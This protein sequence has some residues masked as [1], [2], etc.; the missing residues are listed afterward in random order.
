MWPLAQ[1][2]FVDVGLIEVRVE[3]LV[4][5]FLQELHLD[6]FVGDAC[7]DHCTTLVKVG[8]LQLSVKEDFFCVDVLAS[9][10]SE[11]GDVLRTLGTFSIKRVQCKLA[12]TLPSV[13]KISNG[14]FNLQRVV[15][16]IRKDAVLGNV[17]D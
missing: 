2:Q 17:F 5:A 3:V 12:W 6:A 14:Q 8:V 7:D 15:I 10:Q 11:D 13:R 1:I 16:G 9:E 4:G